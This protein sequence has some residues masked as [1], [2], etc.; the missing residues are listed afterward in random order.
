[1]LWPVAAAPM[2]L[3]GRLWVCRTAFERIIRSSQNAGLEGCPNPAIR[4]LPRRNFDLAFASLPANTTRWGFL[5][6]PDKHDVTTFP[7]PK[8]GKWPV[9]SGSSYQPRWRR[10]GK[11][12][13]YF[14]GDGK[15]MSVDVTL[16]C[17][18]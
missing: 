1:M 2:R 15:L 3:P 5:K 18:T 10:D 17:D 16:R 14:T 13:L 11:E 12:L 9:S 7:D 8:I 6:Q 4:L